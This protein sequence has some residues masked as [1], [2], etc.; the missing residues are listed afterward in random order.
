MG[1][2]GV[3]KKFIESNWVIEKAARE[4]LE[5]LPM[6]FRYGISYGPIFR[7]W[8][9]FLRESEKWESDR[10]KAYQIEQ[11]RDLLIHSGRNVPYYKRVFSEY[12]F[13]PEKFQDLADIK[14]IPYLDRVTIKK[15]HSEFIA[16]NVA[17]Q[18]LIPTATSGTT[19]IPLLVYGTKET[20]EKHWATI[21]D[22]WGRIGFRPGSRTIFLEANIKE[23]KRNG[24]PW[25]RY[26]SKLILSSNFFEPQWIDK[27]V[28]M[29]NRFKP[30]YLVGF[31][32]TIAAFSSYA[33]SLQKSFDKRLKGIIVYAENVYPW[34][35]DIIEEV[36]RARV[37]SDYGQVEKVIHGGGCEHSDS[38]HI[39]PQYGF[40]EYAPLQGGLYELAGTGLIN[41][42]MPFI[43]YKTE[44]VCENPATACPDCGRSYNVIPDL[45]GRGGDFLVNAD[46]QIVSVYL[47]A[48]G[49]ALQKVER[50]QLYQ[51]Y[52]GKVELRVWPDKNY[53]EGDERSVLREVRRCLGPSGDTMEF[54]VELIP[55]RHLESSG[56]Y[57]MVDQRLDIKD[58][59]TKYGNR[60]H[61]TA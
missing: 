60:S 1:T 43:R 56:K 33:K 13:N 37:F 50:F 8:L 20:E 58:F 29:I 36:F 14:A 34:Q 27:F 59:L 18:R 41:Y 9:G 7:Y 47:D 15:K 10:L 6:R 32:H 28:A 53:R 5:R 54:S 17:R 16:E 24:L 12:G 51:D 55:D 49:G 52:P 26:G 48:H 23:G 3:I 44:D 40:T 35:R 45:Q 30:E 38:Y 61:S 11:L 57:R 25:K 39:Y 31:P 19:G 42:A 4:V 21:V 46:R 2:I 22:L